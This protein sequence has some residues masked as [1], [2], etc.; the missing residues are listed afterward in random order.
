MKI[1]KSRLLQ[2]IREEVELHEK[3]TFVFKEA[4]LEAASAED[5]DKDGD[6]QLSKKEKKKAIDDEIAEDERVGNLEEKSKVIKAKTGKKTEKTTPGA[7]KVVK[8]Q[9]FKG[10]VKVFKD[11][12]GID[13]P[14]GMAASAERVAKEKDIKELDVEEDRLFGPKDSEGERPI[15]QPKN[16]GRDKLEIK[17]R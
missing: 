10:A 9:G 7:I 2:I 15:I 6:G 17:I 5:A 12:P 3:N 16:N 1:T 4:E 14:E 8:Q 11:I 13:S